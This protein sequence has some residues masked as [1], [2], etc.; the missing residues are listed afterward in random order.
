[1]SSEQ[2]ELSLFVNSVLTTAYNF[3]TLHLCSNAPLNNEEIYTYFLFVNELSFPQMKMYDYVYGFTVK[4]NNKINKEMSMMF[5]NHLNCLH[6]KLGTVQQRLFQS[7]VKY[8][9]NWCIFN[10]LTTSTVLAEAS[11]ICMVTH[12]F[13]THRC[14]NLN[15][16]NIST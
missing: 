1:M 3:L 5:W 6:W 16:Y 9:S 14:I 8:S 10:D 13:V 11:I 12:S 7:Q 15:L 2:D 4:P